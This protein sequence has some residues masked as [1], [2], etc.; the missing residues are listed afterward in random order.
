[1]VKFSYLLL[2]K[3]GGGGSVDM[4]CNIPYF[5]IMD[6]NIKIS[7]YNEYMRFFQGPKFFFL[8][9]TDLCALIIVSE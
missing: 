3:K 6:L 1:M 8:F 9:T 2:V 7:N 5:G 4:F